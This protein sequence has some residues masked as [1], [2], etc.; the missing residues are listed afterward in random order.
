MLFVRFWNQVSVIGRFLI[1]I[2]MTYFNIKYERK[3][4]WFL[5]ELNPWKTISR[6]AN[7]VKKGK[8]KGKKFNIVLSGLGIFL[9]LG[10]A[11]Q[12]YLSPSPEM[13]IAQAP[14]LNKKITNPYIDSLLIEYN[15]ELQHE[16]EKSNIPGAAVGIVIN[17][18]VEYIKPL[19]VKA[20]DT[21]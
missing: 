20:I 13:T 15:N 19:G 4:N 21:N 10:F 7:F 6:I 17:G 18:Q 8:L 2:E 14:V 16:F 1:N 12:Y 11:S 5:P 3:L 9:I